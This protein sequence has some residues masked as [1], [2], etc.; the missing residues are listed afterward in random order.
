M[1]HVRLAA[2]VILMRPGFEVYLTRR[3]TRSAFAPNA[4][5]F[6]GGTTEAQDASASAQERTLGIEPDRLAREFR[7]EI[8]GGLQSSESPI[9]NGAARALLVA[10]LRELFEEAGVLLARTA[11]MLPIDANAL[12]WRQLA[13]ERARLRGGELSFAQFL[14]RHD[15]FADACALRLFSHW[16][17]PPSEPRRYNTHFFLAEAPPDQIALADAFETHDGLW[18]APGAAL[19]R[20]RSGEL[21]LV[22][23]TIKHLERLVAFD[24]VD[25]ALDFARTKPIV[26]IMPK[27]SGA[28]FQI[29][30]GLEGAW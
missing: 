6:P 14:A 11:T 7:A 13:T 20:F 5:V 2:T 4:F 18:I 21:H 22:Y 1:S 24:S 15:W 3:S 27:D 28:D 9:E 10:A 17:T 16:I 25:A 19:A 23:P 29:P 30:P 26:T 8:A 12:D